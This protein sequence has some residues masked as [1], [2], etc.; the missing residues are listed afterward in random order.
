MIDPFDLPIIL[1]GCIAF[2]VSMYFLPLIVAMARDHRQVLAI[3][4]IPLTT[5]RRDNEQLGIRA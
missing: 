2:V 1:A 4:A 5:K 3:S